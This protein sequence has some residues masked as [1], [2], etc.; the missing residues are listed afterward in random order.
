MPLFLGN[1]DRGL[2]QFAN[3]RELGKKQGVVFLMHPNAH[4][5]QPKLNEK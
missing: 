2:G 4:Y 3:L 1:Y 5:G